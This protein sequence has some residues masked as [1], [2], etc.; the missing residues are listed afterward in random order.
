MG[1]VGIDNKNLYKKV[2][3]RFKLVKREAKWFDREINN[4]FDNHILRQKLTEKNRIRL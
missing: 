4:D 3:P 2:D 1:I